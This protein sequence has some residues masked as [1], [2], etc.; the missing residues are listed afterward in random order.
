[1]TPGAL[2]ALAVEVPAAI[3]SKTMIVNEIVW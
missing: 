1:V 3:A 2:S